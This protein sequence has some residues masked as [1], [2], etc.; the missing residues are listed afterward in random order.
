MT[1]E[2][3]LVELK[4]ADYLKLYM[5][6]QNRA[7]KI[8]EEMFKTLTWTIGF[9]AALLGFIFLN[10]VDFDAS[11]ASVSLSWIVGVS[12]TAG[13]IICIY[14][15]LL[16]SE[17][18]KH[19]KGNWERADRCKEKFQDLNWII[20]GNVKEPSTWMYIWN[21]LRI[22]VTIFCAGFVGVLLMV[23]FTGMFSGGSQRMGVEKALS[24]FW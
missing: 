1:V 17:S 3:T 19:I 7:D 12:A 18:A 11:K 10:L 16:L 14:S 22:I 20:F 24:C 15:W 5:H 9:A 21:Q 6:F 23:L 2:P 4:G 8:K 13:V